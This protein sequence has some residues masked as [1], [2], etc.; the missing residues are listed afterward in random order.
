[1]LDMPWAPLV[2]ATVITEKTWRQFSPET[3]KALMESAREAGELIQQ[4]SRAESL[5]AIQAMQKRGLKVHKVTAEIEKVWR[6][7]CEAFYPRIRGSIVPADMYDEVQRLLAE[8]RS[9]Q[10]PV[11]PDHAAPD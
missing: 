3:Q 7:T 11:G 9:R 8:Y 10:P 6:D 2:G 5:E 4:R 1:M